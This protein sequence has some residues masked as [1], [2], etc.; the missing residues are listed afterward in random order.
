MLLRTSLAASISRHP[1]QV[2]RV[3]PWYFLKAACRSRQPLSEVS[4]ASFA[5]SLMNASVPEVR[6]SNCCPLHVSR[7]ASTILI[8]RRYALCF[9][10]WSKSY[11]PRC[12]TPKPPPRPTKGVGVTRAKSLRVAKISFLASSVIARGEV[13]ITRVHQAAGTRAAS[14]FLPKQLLPL[15]SSRPP[16]RRT[17]VR[18]TC[19]HEAASQSSV[20]RIQS[21]S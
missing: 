3:T 2:P 17:L 6:I 16:R 9:Q 18:Q 12:D 13:R 15:G 20:L 14:N 11:L 1:E 19:K 7:N 5:S 21:R 10:T 4:R 8:S